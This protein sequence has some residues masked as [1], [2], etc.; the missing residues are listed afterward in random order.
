MKANNH[1]IPLKCITEE[2][3]SLTIVSDQ[4]QS[5]EVLSDDRPAWAYRI[6]EEQM[7]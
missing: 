6:N 1:K 2:T 4:G 3:N 7:F 5:I